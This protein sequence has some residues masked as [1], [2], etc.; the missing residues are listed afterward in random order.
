MYP[1]PQQYQFTLRTGEPATGEFTFYIERLKTFKTKIV[2]PK[3]ENEVAD[4]FGLSFV[5]PASEY[6]GADGSV[7][8]F[9]GNF[10]SI[11]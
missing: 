4:E 9:Q 8:S 1:F 7:P 10:H 2:A 6:Q 3:S 11:Q 5:G